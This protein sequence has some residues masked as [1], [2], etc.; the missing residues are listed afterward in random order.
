M[1]LT[2]GYPI[3]SNHQCSTPP[4]L[5]KI[6]LHAPVSYPVDLELETEACAVDDHL[7]GEIEVVEFNAAGGSEAGEEA[8][9][10]GAEVRRERAHVGEIP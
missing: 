8:A 6:R 2:L 7:E 4:A 9:G 5:V 3:P 1:P 10:H